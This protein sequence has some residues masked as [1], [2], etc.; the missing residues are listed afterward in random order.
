M[1][2]NEYHDYCDDL[3]VSC[4]IIPTDDRDTQQ[5][6][7][8]VNDLAQQVQQS[9]K[10]D[11][12]GEADDDAKKREEELENTD[13]TLA[14]DFGDLAMK[15]GENHRGLLAKRNLVAGEVILTENAM[16]YVSDIVFK[17]IR[18]E[19]NNDE[20]KGC[21]PDEDPYF[22]TRGQKGE[23]RVDVIPGDLVGLPG[24]W[25]VALA[26]LLIQQREDVADLAITEGPMAFFGRHIAH[27]NMPPEEAYKHALRHYAQAWGADKLARW[28]QE[29]FTKLYCVMQVNA[30]L[31]YLPLSHS[32]YAAALFTAGAFL[33]HSCMPNAIQFL[34][35]GGKSVLQATK[36][37]KAGE[38]IVISYKEIAAD[39]LSSD[40]IRYLHADM[41][42]DQD[43]GCCCELCDDVA[44]SMMEAGEEGPRNTERIVDFDVRTLWDT[45]TNAAICADDQFASYVLNIIKNPDDKLA[46]ASFCALRTEFTRYFVAKMDGGAQNN[47]AYKHDLALVLAELYCNITIHVPGQDA[48]DYRFWPGI[49]LNA[50]IG[51]NVP[52]FHAINTGYF[53]RAYGMVCSMRWR[54]SPENHDKEDACLALVKG[55]VYRM[56]S[57]EAAIEAEDMPHF[58]DAWVHIKMH[59]SNLFGHVEALAW[60]RRVYRDVDELCEQYHNILWKT[61]TF[62]RLPPEE[63]QRY[64][65][66][67][68][69]LAKLNGA[70]PPPP[71]N[72]AK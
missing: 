54:L 48:E 20:E 27:K 33:N 71:N 11:D 70:P 34:F 26:A 6:E 49:Y 35:P 32:V 47:P 68:Q 56:P 64:I 8:E 3:S 1:N 29:E 66:K 58:V 38:E 62:A 45:K 9:M 44:S 22:M 41:G 30:S 5:Q 17:H 53:A 7:E 40:M 42:L 28:P 60:F 12:G 24:G 65:E 52:M 31:K 51:S 36:P 4:A 37:I 16:V 61:E 50:V 25:F 46:A 57:P 14:F 18:E 15:Y 2:G 21:K 23:V 72:D 63:Q 19:D 10:F 55:Q 43:R 67:Q 39:V 13:A 59:N 69:E